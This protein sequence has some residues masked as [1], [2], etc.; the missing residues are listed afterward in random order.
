[1][2]KTFLIALF[3]AAGMTL[4]AQTNTRRYP[5]SSVQRSWQRDYP[6]RDN[7]AWEYRNNQWH[8]KYYDRDHNNREV[9]V[10]YDRYGRRV[11][12]QTQ[13]DRND[14]P[15]R[16]RNRIRS[17][18][19]TENYSAYRVERPGGRFYFQIRLGNNRLLYLDER[20]RE[21]RNR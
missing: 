4:F 10:Y 15:D 8:T 14:L 13:W 16:V 11:Y 21:T 7:D 5:P 18:Y 17:R 9:H 3:C 6:N 1:M 2:K 20:G 19:R 12:S